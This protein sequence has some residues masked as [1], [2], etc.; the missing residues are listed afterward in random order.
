MRDREREKEILSRVWVSAWKTGEP[1]KSC[2]R[3]TDGKIIFAQ[4]F[5]Y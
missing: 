4:I 5:L 1:G 3:Q 2:L